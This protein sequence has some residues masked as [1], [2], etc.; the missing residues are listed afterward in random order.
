MNNT[1][2]I[3][4]DLSDD[5]WTIECTVDELFLCL[6]RTRRIITDCKKEDDANNRIIHFRKYYHQARMLM[7]RIPIAKPTP[8]FIVNISD[9]TVRIIAELKALDKEGS[10]YVLRQA[11]GRI[12]ENI[13][14]KKYH[15]SIAQKLKVVLK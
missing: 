8:E 7:K 13:D 3:D 12:F 10:K 9:L 2:S 6:A 5:E 15:L 1:S 14:S 11:V 4:I